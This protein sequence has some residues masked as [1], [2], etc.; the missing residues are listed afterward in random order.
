MSQTTIDRIRRRRLLKISLTAAAVGTT[1][2]EEFPTDSSGTPTPADNPY[3]DLRETVVLTRKPW[4]ETPEEVAYEMSKMMAIQAAHLGKAAI[5]GN[6]LDALKSTG[7]SVADSFDALAEGEISADRELMRG[8]VKQIYAREQSRDT[9]QLMIHYRQLE[10]SYSSS[11]PYL[12]LF[13]AL[14][15]DLRTLEDGSDA[16]ALDALRRD[17]RAVEQILEMV[18]QSIQTGVSGTN[19][20]LVGTL[21]FLWKTA[22]I[23]QDV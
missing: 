22:K 19:D 10:G 14:I 8:A 17:G 4:L 9:N 23:V 11:Q 3:T 16:E 6:S 13:G 5:R 18:W 15:S 12:P 7:E 20:P 21:E 1:G 2:C